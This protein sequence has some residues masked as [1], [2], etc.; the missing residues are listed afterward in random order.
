[1]DTHVIFARIGVLADTDRTSDAGTAIAGGAVD[2]LIDSV[3]LV[4]K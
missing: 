1:M 4:P 3:T 2:I